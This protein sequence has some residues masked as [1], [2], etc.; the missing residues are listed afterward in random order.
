ML[1]KQIP[2][3]LLG[4]VLVSTIYAQDA[5]VPQIPTPT[6]GNVPNALSD[7][8][9]PIDVLDLIEEIDP[10][11]TSIS[12]AEARC[13]RLDIL[14]V[15]TDL[16]FTQATVLVD[17]F[18]NIQNSY[19]SANPFPNILTAGGYK[20]YFNNPG[21]T[22]PSQAQ[23]KTIEMLINE[24]SVPSGLAKLESAVAPFA[25][26][27]QIVEYATVRASYDG[28][29]VSDLVDLYGSILSVTPTGIGGATPS[30][31]L[32][33][34]TPA[35]ATVGGNASTATQTG[36]P[37]TSLSSGFAAPTVSSGVVA[38]ALA[39]AAGVVGIAFL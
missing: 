24:V 32:A 17:G 23:I 11:I 19:H 18:V 25:F 20:S 21:T 5:S 35:S 36:S 14:K 26:S 16:S 12:E 7:P 31:T 27:S 37:S 10:T 38:Q 30:T 15:V 1:S 22:T 4:A 29:L 34:T 28:P 33:T 6:L 13:Q 39:A 9:M 3:G 2:C 8:A